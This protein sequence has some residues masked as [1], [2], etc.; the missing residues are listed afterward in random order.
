MLS[1]RPI[2][3][4]LAALLSCPL[5]AF[6]TIVVFNEVHYHPAGHDDPDLEFIELFNQN[7]V[8]ID[9]TG[10]R[11][12]GEVD[13]AFPEGTTIEGGSYLVIAAN[14]SA[15]ESASGQSGFLG[16]F[17]GSLGNG[18][19]TLRLRNNNDRILDELDYDDRFPWPI[20]ADG[21]GASLS[22]IAPR[23]STAPVGHWT[24]SFPVVGTPGAENFPADP[25]PSPSHPTGLPLTINEIAGT[26][27]ASFWI[28]LYNAGALEIA[29]ESF[30]LE[31][32]D[33]GSYRFPPGVTIPA[34]GFR[35]VT[36]ET[37]LLPEKPLDGENLYLYQPGQP[38]GRN[39]VDAIRIDDLPLGRSPDGAD[40]ILTVPSSA[41][42]TPGEPNDITTSEAIVI[43]E[44][45]YHHRPTYLSGGDPPII[46][47][48]PGF[49]WNTEWRFN[50]SGED[51]G[52]A[53]A[54]SVHFVGGNWES[55]P[56]PLGYEISAGRPPEAIVTQLNRPQANNPRVVT[57]YFETEFTVDPA[58]HPLITALHF[59]HQTD[60]GAVYY[61]NGQEIH[62]FD[63]PS[64]VITA[65]TVA[66]NDVSTEADEIRTFSVEPEFLQAGSNRLS[67]ELHQSSAGSNDVVMGLKL[68]L[69]RSEPGEDPP[70]P[71]AENGEEWIELLNRS[72][73]PV[74]LDHWELEGAVDFTFPAG[75]VLAPGHYLVIARDLAAF[76]AKFPG[77]S[78]LGDFSGSLANSGE[79]L[80]LLDRWNNPVDE[81]VYLDGAP[82]PKPADGGGSSLELRHPD[83]DNTAPSSWA[84][85][86][87][88][89]S[90][91]WRTYSYTL[92][93]HTPVYRP[94]QFGFHELRLG[95][96]DAGE[97]LIDDFSV[98][99]DPGGADLELIENGSFETTDGW[100][101]LG[102]HQDSHLVTDDGNS[103]LK[104]S[105]VSRMNYLN[106]LIE[107]NL[108]S[109]G[110]LRNVT[111]GTDYRVSFRAKWLTGSPQFRFEFYY[112]KLAEVVILAQPQTHGTP[113]ARNSTFAPKVGPTLTGLLHQPAV[114]TTSEPVTISVQASDPD[115][116]DTLT[117][118]YSVNRR[119]FQ[120][121]PMSSDNGYDFKTTFPAQSHNALIH[122]YVQARDQE[123]NLSF[124]PPLG[125]DSRALIRV[126]TPNP[127]GAKQSIRVNMLATEASA[128]HAFRDI[129]DNKRRGCTIII[130]EEDI[131][132][133][134]G[135]RLRGSM[136]S[137]NSSARVG[138]NLKLPS[139][140][141]FRGVHSTITLRNGNRREL[142]VKHIINAAGGLHDNYN[143]IV[144]Y[145]GH[146]STYNSLSR[147]EMARFGGDYLDGFPGGDGDEGTVF[148]MEGIRIFQTTQDGTKNTPKLPFP[149]GWVSSF[150]LADQGDLKEDYRHNLRI[151]TALDRDRYAEV[152]EMAKLFSLSGTDLEE[153][154]P[155]VIDVDMWCRQFALTSLCGVQDTYSQGNPHNLNFYTRPGGLV[156]PVPWDWDNHFNRST[157]AP[158]WGNRNVAKLFSRPVF[159]RLYHGHLHDLINRT[160]NSTYLTPWLS[161]LGSCA[162]ENF[163]SSLGYI[164]NRG[165]FVRSRLPAQIPFTITTNGGDNFE[166]DGSSV[167]VEGRA[168]IDVREVRIAGTPSALP[169]TWLDEERWEVQV[170]LFPGANAMTLTGLDFSGD[171]VGSDT[172]TITNTGTTEPAS[173]ANLV[174]S[175]IHYH[176]TAN[177]PEEFIELQNIS[178]A[179]I[180]LSGVTFTD[181]IDF[182]FSSGTLLAPG[183]HLLVVLDVA[184]FQARYGVGLNLAGSFAN[185]TRLSNGGETVR[186]ESP[187][188]L[189]I[190]EIPYNDGGAW[191]L[192]ADGS[193]PSL[194]LRDPASNPDPG[195]STSWR[196]STLAGGSPGVTDPIGFVGDPDLDVDRD[197][198]SAF[199]EYAMGTSDRLVGDADGLITFIINADK[200][201]EFTIPVSSALEEIT[202]RIEWSSDLT[203]WHDAGA[204]S[205]LTDETLAGGRLFRTYI[206]NNAV[207]TGPQFL[208][209][210]FLE[211]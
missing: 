191:P 195:L 208:R 15:L 3:A 103:V 206:S 109:G 175:E 189:L 111:A 75:L 192:A 69:E 83:L 46:T 106:N 115:G 94:N 179:T 66:T 62:R 51:L 10:W 79:H 161:H 29:L 82:W 12:S 54:N 203:S 33:A 198:F 58:D 147:L 209:V 34:Q 165:N 133:D 177:R 45:M 86:D 19:G 134:A 7:A 162:G 168:W 88:E 110:S 6:D 145:H 85:S 132:Y 155:G 112:N 118:Y 116:L 91:S 78:A 87:N 156:E 44:I 11:I 84:A 149:I 199:A 180:D 153:A 105:A 140:K 67:V 20:G 95:L 17:T 2:L 5:L 73:S 71:F 90:S 136:W 25:T 59:S 193:G 128:M 160:F 157:S 123:G 183:E 104:I 80:R 52:L 148:K 102:T 56:G 76:S 114:P 202:L 152:I 144:R 108:T 28:E 164:R 182:E 170:P 146:L 150:D 9:L 16:P 97:I 72:D 211:E 197:G 37:L 151:N 39:L 4:G 101:L 188:G 60:D 57:F 178:G 24:P 190:Q 107:A 129:L 119:P 135:I 142:A 74:S 186:L 167:T 55:G 70:T 176:P 92:T 100:R 174:I 43:N 99:E 124:A 27:E 122:F 47:E 154:A 125:P 184:A 131:A 53:W 32:E 36:A 48:I 42:Q 68:D 35:L 141:L 185:G 207:S 196:A 163:S 8:N 171:A 113:G 18:G 64:G 23:K 61:L 137:R 41:E 77:V 96:L 138:F 89:T 201:W 143:D 117:L 63:M 38:D 210:R 172:I 13:F 205:T 30:V 50:Q 127:G 187:A 139:D 173:A 204:I 21:S 1:L 65:D 49:G 93:A 130:D 22:K 169:L 81:V 126:T 31:F 120:E 194:V 26:T 159:R 40:Q 200:H 158:L 121:L 181:G 14:P 166:H 98:V